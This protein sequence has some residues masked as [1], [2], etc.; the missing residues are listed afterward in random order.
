MVSFFGLG[1]KKKEAPEGQA[2]VHSLYAQQ[3]KREQSPF[4][5]RIPQPSTSPAGLPARPSSSHSSRSASPGGQKSLYANRSATGSMQDLSTS[6]SGR[7]GS[8]KLPRTGSP[9]RP[10][11]SDGGP[12]KPNLGN[13]RPMSPGSLAAAASQ[14]GFRFENSPQQRPLA[15][16]PTRTA[17]SISSNNSDSSNNNNNNNNTNTNMRPSPS[18]IERNRSPLG[19]YEVRSEAE[20]SEVSSPMSQASR[21]QAGT[22]RSNVTSLTSVASSSD[23]DRQIGQWAVKV[24]DSSSGGIDEKV[25][26]PT[27]PLFSLD[28]QEHEREREREQQGDKDSALLDDSEENG[29]NRLD[30]ISIS[31]PRASLMPLSAHDPGAGTDGRGYSMIL[32]YYLDSDARESMVI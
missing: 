3:W 17:S 31:E 6:G 21:S 4:G 20:D 13:A 11:S 27:S 1:K 5:P 24:S 29:L 9:L 7:P 23:M 14:A 22:A 28:E 18:S 30:T 15:A 8:G 10:T 16:H 19:R 32:Q 25:R 26:S 12:K 2:P